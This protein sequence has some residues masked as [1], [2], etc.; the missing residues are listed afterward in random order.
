MEHND[1]WLVKVPLVW[2]DFRESVESLKALSFAHF[3]SSR[4]TGTRPVEFPLIEFPL[5]EI[6]SIN[7]LNLFLKKLVKTGFVSEIP[8]HHYSVLS[9]LCV[10]VVVLETFKG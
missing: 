3:P 6:K 9:L 2:L 4:S 5:I 8:E 1:T 7:A 10:V